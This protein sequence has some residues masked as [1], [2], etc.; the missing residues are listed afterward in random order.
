[1]EEFLRESLEIYEDIGLSQENLIKLIF[2]LQNNH[3]KEISSIDESDAK[4]AIDNRQRI[5]CTLH[6]GLIILNM[7]KINQHSLSFI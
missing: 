4:F 6:H 1:M 7:S 5:K 2:I 3:K